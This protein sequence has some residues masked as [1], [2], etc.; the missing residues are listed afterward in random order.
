MTEQQFYGTCPD[1]LPDVLP[2]GTV[3]GDETGP[4]RFTLLEPS[5]LLGA[6]DYQHV[7]TRRSDGLEQNG[8]S[9]VGPNA[10]CVFWS[11][12]PIQEAKPAESPHPPLTLEWLKRTVS[13]ATGSP[14][15]ASSESAAEALVTVLWMKYDPLDRDA[16]AEIERRNAPPPPAPPPKPRLP[17]VRSGL[18]DGK[19]RCDAC[20]HWDFHH[21]S[22][23]GG[24]PPSP[25]HALCDRAAYGDGGNE[26]EGL[27][28]NDFEG[29][30]AVLWTLSDFGCVLFEEKKDV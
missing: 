27:V 29:Y 5:R 14:I 16:A 21:E 11:T 3:Y 8:S 30:A 24:C 10:M 20:K 26:S 22:R 18:V 23:N 12:V 13:E 2:A 1:V 15:V 17:M 28:V 4:N 25:A 6:G 19:L 9:G 7:R